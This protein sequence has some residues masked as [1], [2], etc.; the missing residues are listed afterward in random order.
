MPNIDGKALLQNP[1]ESGLSGDDLV[2]ALKQAVK[3]FSYAALENAKYYRD[4]IPDKDELA[5]LLTQAAE[6]APFTTL[7]S[8][9]KYILNI[10]EKDRT[11]LLIKAADETPGVALKYP[12]KYKLRL[13]NS[14][15][16]P[17][18]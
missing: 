9:D 5:Q 1:A 16:W 11:E 13:V 18:N 10:P 7:E 3:D 2:V 12:D 4:Y 8:A 14:S 17:I 15:I 6:K